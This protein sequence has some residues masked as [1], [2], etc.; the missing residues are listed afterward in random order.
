MK[1]EEIK[2][3][4]S[5]YVEENSSVGLPKA[6][7][8]RMRMLCAVSGGFTAFI[9]ALETLFTVVGLLGLSHPENA[10]SAV[11]TYVFGDLGYKAVSVC[12]SLLTAVTFYLYAGKK[13]RA[14]PFRYAA[15]ALIARS[16]AAV[17][18]IAVPWALG[19]LGFSGGVGS[20]VSSDGYLIKMVEPVL[21]VLA[22]AAISISSMVYICGYFAATVDNKKEGSDCE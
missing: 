5:C 16:A 7:N 12:L 8:R 17:I 19:I 20:L 9:L 18:L 11:N 10:I 22:T 14:L 4:T 15:N 1:S 3:E 13:R 6:E 21:K 2:K